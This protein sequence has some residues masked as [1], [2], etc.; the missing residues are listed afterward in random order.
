MDDDAL[1]VVD[2]VEFEATISDKTFCCMGGKTMTR[3]GIFEE[4]ICTQFNQSKTLLSSK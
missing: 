2:I 4:G 1:A 3:R